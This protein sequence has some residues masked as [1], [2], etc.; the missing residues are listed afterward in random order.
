MGG[1]SNAIFS[2][3]RRSIGIGFVS[4]INPTRE[5]AESLKVGRQEPREV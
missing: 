3:S 1:E 4:P 5:V 2:H